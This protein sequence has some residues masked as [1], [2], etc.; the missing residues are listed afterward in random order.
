MIPRLKVNDV[1]SG[2]DNDGI[3]YSLAHTFPTTIPWSE[4]LG[5]IFD[6]DYVL[7][8]SGN[9]YI[10]TL[11]DNL[12]ENGEIS[13]GNFAKLINIINARCGSNFAHLLDVRDA[14][15]DPIENYSMH[16]V[17]TPS[18]T[19]TDKRVTKSDVVTV[20]ETGTENSRFGYNSGNAVPSDAASSGGQQRVTMSPDNNE[21]NTTHTRTGTET[22]DRSGNI[23]VTTS[24]Q[25]LESEIALWQQDMIGYVY[26]LVDKIVTLPI[27]ESIL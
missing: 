15:Y 9:K 7:G 2:G 11:V 13:E 14:E 20:S 8:Y 17:V 10:S 16:E 12:V 4:T 27:Y 25:M 26:G 6:A 22:T 1:I 18:L 21:V 23:G 5:N 24:Q 3:F 19:D